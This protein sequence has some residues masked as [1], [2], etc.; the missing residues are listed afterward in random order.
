[1]NNHGRETE[2]S[3]DDNQKRYYFISTNFGW[4]TT[5]I[6]PFDKQAKRLSKRHV[7]IFNDIE[8]LRISLADN[9]FQG[10]G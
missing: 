6:Q 7:S 10:D 2:K 5:P 8:A 9:P 1:M 3:I 4:H